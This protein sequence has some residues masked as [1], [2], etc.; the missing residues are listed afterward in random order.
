MTYSVIVNDNIY[1]IILTEPD[2]Q[3]AI[4]LDVAEDH[5]GKIAK[6]LNLTK[7]SEARSSVFDEY[8]EK[9]ELQICKAHYEE[10][11]ADNPEILEMLETTLDRGIPL[12]VL[13]GWIEGMKQP[14]ELTFKF[15]C[16][17]RWYEASKK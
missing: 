15:Y 16:A 1:S 10:A 13:K 4:C 9:V 12:A 8:R 11:Q 6:L 5:A 3:R 2:G 7:G 14:E 17:A